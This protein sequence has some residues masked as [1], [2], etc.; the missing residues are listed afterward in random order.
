MKRLFFTVAAMLSMTLASAENG[1]MN[2]VSTV[3]NVKVYD[4]SVNMKQLARALSL[5]DDQKEAVV[6]IYNTFCSEVMFAA[7][8]PKEECNAR[9]DAAIKKNLGYMNYILTPEQ[10]RKY[11]MLLNITMVNRGLR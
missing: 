5:A 8:Y 10:Y 1:N 2:S 11:R 3:N 9:M 4:L 6:E 7:Q